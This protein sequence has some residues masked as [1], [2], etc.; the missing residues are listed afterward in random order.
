[1]KNAEANYPLLLSRRKLLIHGAM[2]TA[3][4]A[5]IGE[6]G[7]QTAAGGTKIGKAADSSITLQI[8]KGFSQNQLDLWDAVIHPDVKSNSPAGRNIDGIAALKRWNQSFIDSFRP[9]TDLVDHFVAGDR[10]LVTINLHWKHD[11]PFNGLAPTGKTGT[12]V[13]N[14]ILRIENGLVTRWDVAD[15]SL[16][17]AI[18]LHDEGLK[19]PTFVEPPA[20]IKGVDLP[21]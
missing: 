13:E 18:Y 14:F 7:A 8:Y 2:S 10:G 20:L 9:R 15:G 1:M 5:L 4:L 6:A 21:F 19:M 12:S 16:D 11:R 3:G 17:L